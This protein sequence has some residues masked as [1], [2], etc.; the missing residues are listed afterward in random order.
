MAAIPINVILTSKLM[1]TTQVTR[2]MK[3]YIFITKHARQQSMNNEI[4]LLLKHDRDTKRKPKPR[5]LFRLILTIAPVSVIPILPRMCRL[6]FRSESFFEQRHFAL[7][8]KS[9]LQHYFLELDFQ[10]GKGFLNPS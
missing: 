9:H 10:E 5:Q 1:F 7:T 8:I 2:K 4:M 6:A 3:A